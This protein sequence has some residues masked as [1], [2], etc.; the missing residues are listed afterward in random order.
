M[1]G[2]IGNDQIQGIKCKLSLQHISPHTTG[3]YLQQNR[4]KVKH[5]K[6]QITSEV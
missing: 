1:S 4:T 3:V 6:L 2:I 5:L